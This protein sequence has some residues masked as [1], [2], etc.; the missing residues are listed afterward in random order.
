MDGFATE[1]AQIDAND[2]QIVAVAEQIPADGSGAAPD[3][4]DVRAR[5]KNR[6]EICPLFIQRVE[7]IAENEAASS[8]PLLVPK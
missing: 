8:R 1:L 2:L 6:S 4:N 5:R 3:I 7:R